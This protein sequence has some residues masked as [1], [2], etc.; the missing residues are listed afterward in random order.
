[1]DEPL[2]SMGLQVLTQMH[3]MII[4]AIG[5]GNISRGDKILV[6]LCDP[7]DGV[8]SLDTNMLNANRFATLANETGIELEVLTKAM[9][10]ARHIGS[11]GREGHSVGAIFAIG[12]IP[13]I[14]KVL[15][16]IGVKSIQR[17]RCIKKDDNK[18]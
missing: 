17:P 6:A 7:I 12:S 18:Q 9:E 13:K 8:F 3:D 2:S 14:E 16:S 10:L 1:M 5:E 4:Q 15:D 11:R